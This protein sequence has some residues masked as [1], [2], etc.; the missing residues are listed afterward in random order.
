MAKENDVV[1][2]HLEDTPLTY[3]RIESITADTKKDWYHVTL[4]LLQIPLQT[5]TWILKEAYINGESFHMGGK[6]MK[7]SPVKAPVTDTATSPETEEPKQ[8][9][10]TEGDNVV[11]F[12]AFKNAK[13]S[14]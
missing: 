2:I 6:P 9:E 12:D 13:R 5:V 7:L 4:L 11:S 10:Q 1:L 8:K 3:A 14:Q